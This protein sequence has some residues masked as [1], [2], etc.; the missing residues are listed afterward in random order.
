MNR[1]FDIR[2]KAIEDSDSEDGDALSSGDEGGD[3]E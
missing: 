2:R 3:W 1:A